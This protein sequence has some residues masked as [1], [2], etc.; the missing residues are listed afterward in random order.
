MN[1]SDDI[2]LKNAIKSTFREIDNSIKP[3]DFQEDWNQAKVSHEQ[4][5]AFLKKL[6][7]DS[8]LVTFTRFLFSPPVLLIAPL[9]L[10]I[11][12]IYVLMVNMAPP[13]DLVSPLNTG[14]Q[15]QVTSLDPNKYWRAPTDGLL[16][17]DVR[18][19]ETQLITFVNYDPLSMEIR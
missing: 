9:S 11:V 15:A 6:F 18:K 4:Q 2:L 13:D 1:N 5:P 10:M 3:S 19:Y 17:I 12:G 14:A 7:P 8:S 16:Q